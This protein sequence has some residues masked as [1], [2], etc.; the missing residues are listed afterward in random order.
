MLRLY[1]RVLCFRVLTSQASQFSA[2]ITRTAHYLPERGAI[3]CDTHIVYKVALHQWKTFIN[4]EAIV[5]SVIGHA[6]HVFG[7]QLPFFI[8]LFQD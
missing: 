7:E 5:I 2:K 4:H 6:L 3:T 1:G 8:A